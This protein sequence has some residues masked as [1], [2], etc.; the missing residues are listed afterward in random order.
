MYVPLILAV[1]VMIF[2][3]LYYCID[4]GFNFAVIP[5]SLLCGLLAFLLGCLIVAFV[6]D[7]CVK[8]PKYYDSTSETYQLISMDVSESDTYLT[9]QGNPKAEY[10]FV[11]FDDDDNV[12][13]VNQSYGVSCEYNKK[14][15]ASVTITT[16][17]LKDEYSNWLFNLK[18]ETYELTLPSKDNVLVK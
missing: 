7:A 5:V 16:Y 18:P 3:I 1:I 14:S 6:S 17:T 4:F 9:I 2:V 10:I 8:N 12:S 15:K 13:V 11:Y